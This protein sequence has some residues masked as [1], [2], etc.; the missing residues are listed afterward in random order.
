MTAQ[1]RRR[2]RRSPRCRS[3]PPGSR[4]VRLR[5][6]DLDEEGVWGE[7]M[8]QSIGLWCSLIEDPTADRRR[9]PRRERVARVGDRQALAPDR[10]VPA[11][12][13][14]HARRRRRRQ[15]AASTPPII[16]LHIVSLP[17]GSPPGTRTT[18]TT[19]GSRCG[20]PPRRPAWSIGFH[21][22]T[23][24]GDQAAKFRG[25]GGAILNYVETTYGGQY[26]AHED[27]RSR[28]S[29]SGTPTSRC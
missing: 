25:P 19:R 13:M 2:A 17:T 18:T 15:G 11:A 3:R 24:G 28:A 12:L 16:G 23:D 27:G 22:G 6:Q 10:L 29:S 8:Y 26:A 1:G 21:I 5:L 7:V 9:G 4:D 20:P 14:P